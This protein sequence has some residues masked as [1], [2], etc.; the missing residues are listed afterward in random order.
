MS[1]PAH[2]NGADQVWKFSQAWVSIAMLC[3]FLIVGLVFGMML[4]AEKKA[5]AGDKGA[6]KIISAVGGVLHLLLVIVLVMMVFK[7]GFKFS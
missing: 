7:P 5:A 3:W 4:P 1:K 6:E 2:A